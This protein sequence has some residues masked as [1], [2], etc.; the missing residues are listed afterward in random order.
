MPLHS[1]KFASIFILFALVIAACNG[2]E[3][4]PATPAATETP[5]QAP[6]AAPTITPTPAG[7]WISL[8]PSH[9]KPG[10]TIQVEGYSPTAPT[11]L[12]SG[13]AQVY[14]NLCWDGCQNGLQ[15][16]GLQA[17][18]STTDPGHFSL[19]FV[20]PSAPWLAADGPHDLASGDYPISIEYM[21]FGSTACTDPTAKGC[22][23]TIDAGQPFHLDGS[24]SVQSCASQGCGSLTVTPGKGTAGETIQ[25]TGWAPLLEMIGTGAGDYSGYSLVLL[26]SGTT[27]NP[28]NLLNSGLPVSQT[29][30][31]SLT[32]SFQVP[33][34]GPNGPLAA[35]TYTL[36]LNADS[37][38]NGLAAK[39]GNWQP[40]L[41]ASISFEVTTVPAWSQLQVTAPVWIQSSTSLLS[42]T[43]GLD[44]AN[45]SRIASCVTGAIKVSS[46]GGASWTSISTEA[47]VK[48]ADDMGYSIGLQQLPACNS[49][50]LDPT[51]PQS[52]YAVFGG[53]N[54]QY[55]APPTYFLGFYTT[56]NGTTWKAAP[57][58]PETQNAPM[59]ER[60]GGFW[61]DGQAIQAL[62]SGDSSGQP[63]QA[64]PVLVEQTTDGGVSWQ[65]GA[66]TCPA[67][68]PCLRWGAAP[69]SISGMGA[70]LPQFV[71]VSEDN[72]TT[73]SSSGQYVELHMS[74]PDEL[75]A[76]SA[77]EAVLISG[78]A[79]Y[80]LLVTQDSG[81]TWQ[82]YALP[83][84]PGSQSF[85]YQFNGLQI[86]PDGSLVAMNPDTGT[87]YDLPPGGQ[88]WCASKVTIPGYFPVLLQASGDK[89]WWISP[90]D[91]SLQSTALSEFACK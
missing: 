50:V 48:I 20:V 83:S 72:G 61:N 52:F 70:S 60:F 31:G 57:T 15:E 33:L 62:Y 40:V 77:T 82:A 28:Q 69:G 43:P 71:M 44:P 5:T 35:G 45:S 79:T 78:G 39:G 51:R 27:S 7:A 18:W 24:A 75:S 67:S 53:A 73:W 64:A 42:Q 26:E 87:W 10:D 65:A 12:Q 2:Y 13:A 55:G 29:V 91:G 90:T 59:I 49:V 74:G 22:M 1:A 58:P 47:V 6:T 46:D 54:K 89:A 34:S 11:G 38:V 81:K 19:S 4:R 86:L 37:L 21:D 68:G 80:P 84:L 25:V 23:L 66:L 14:T 88:D 63:G 76:L 41:V 36:G 30:N 8:S 9:G 85:G 56:D 16:Q 3:L 17:D 32:A